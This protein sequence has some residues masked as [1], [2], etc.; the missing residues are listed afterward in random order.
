MSRCPLEN[1]TLFPGDR[2]MDGL[3]LLVLLIAALLLGSACGPPRGTNRNRRPEGP[4]PNPSPPPPP[5]R[6]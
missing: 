3:L 4:K 6:W 5:P 2:E 1:V